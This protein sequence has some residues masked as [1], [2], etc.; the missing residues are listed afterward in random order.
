MQYTLTCSS[1][2]YRSPKPET[3]TPRTVERTMEVSFGDSPAKNRLTVRLT[4]TLPTHAVA[5][6]QDFVRRANERDA[7]S[8]GILAATLKY[9]SP[10][11]SL[12]F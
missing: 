2:T 4:K 7:R 6:L 12:V 1:R 5:E 10:D 11:V 8:D 3:M 9:E